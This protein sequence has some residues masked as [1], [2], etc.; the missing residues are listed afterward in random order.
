MFSDMIPQRFFFPVSP[1]W[2][3]VSVSLYNS[4]SELEITQPPNPILYQQHS[5]EIGEYGK[6]ESLAG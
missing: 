6:F 2:L 4:K 1:V 3:W 5:G